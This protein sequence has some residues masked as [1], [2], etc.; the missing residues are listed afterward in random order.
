MSILKLTVISDEYFYKCMCTDLGVHKCIFDYCFWVHERHI[1][2]RIF[3][4]TIPLFH[5][6][7]NNEPISSPVCNLMAIIW[8]L[9]SR[10]L[11]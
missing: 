10:L 9:N 11:R 6:N 4:K 3:L 7:M 5:F 2:A 8:G 1:V